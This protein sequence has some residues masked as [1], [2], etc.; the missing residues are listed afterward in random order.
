MSFKTKTKLLLVLIILI[1]VV[2]FT[3]KDAISKESILTD[4]PYRNQ[5]LS[6]P[7][8]AYGWSSCGYTCMMMS[9]LYNQALPAGLTEQD[10]LKELRDNCSV[11]TSDAVFYNWN[12]SDEFCRDYLGDFDLKVGYITADYETE[13]ENSIDNGWPVIVGTYIFGNVGH[14]IL[15][16]GYDD[17]NWIVHDPANSW[18]REYTPDSWWAEE[19]AFVKYPRGSF[20]CLY[21]VVISSDHLNSNDGLVILP[22]YDDVVHLG[23]SY[24]SGAINGDFV[25]EEA[26]C[27]SVC[28]YFDL[29]SHDLDGLNGCYLSMRVAGAQRLWQNDKANP[30]Y[31]NGE[32]ATEIVVK[33]QDAAFNNT[34]HHFYIYKGLLHEGRNQIF[35]RSRTAPINDGTRYMEFDDFEISEVCFQFDYSDNLLQCYEEPRVE[36]ADL[37]LDD[38]VELEFEA[39][40][41]DDEKEKSED[42]LQELANVGGQIVPPMDE[43]HAQIA[44]L[45]TPLTTQIGQFIRIK[46]INYLLFESSTID[47][48]GLPDGTLLIPT[49]L[50]KYQHDKLDNNLDQAMLFPVISALV[51]ADLGISYEQVKR[52]NKAGV[53]AFFGSIASC[54]SNNDVA[55][56]AG[57]ALKVASAL[58]M[59]AEDKDFYLADAYAMDILNSMG[60]SSN[61]AFSYLDATYSYEND[62]PDNLETFYMFA[63]S[64][65]KRLNAL[66]K[67]N[68]V[69]NTNDSLVSPLYFDFVKAAGGDE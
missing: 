32:E 58:T 56:Y 60:L 7:D 20:T 5:I 33:N 59:K 37:I 64:A 42:I 11:V 38:P 52:K 39:G 30:V 27:K 55:N 8:W 19:A 16:V 50:V 63:P 44:Q 3:Y 28:W 62:N 65:E 57:Q 23:D 47:P 1:L 69:K 41:S 12:L 48:I 67:Y 10:L 43:R 21:G 26:E 40:F 15:V 29:G 36:E 17:E 34:I 24:Y 13:L 49:G 14:V 53:L 2:A 9:I 18:G 31:I 68:Y 51:R 4:V 35:I 45:L 22:I 6:Y 66:I 54:F 46:K 25:K 61:E